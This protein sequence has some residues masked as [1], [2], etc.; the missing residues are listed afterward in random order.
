M[1]VNGFDMRIITQCTAMHYVIILSTAILLY[2]RHSIQ[3]RIAWLA[4]STFVVIA[5]NALRLIIT[6]VIGSISW[7]AFVL[8]HDYLWVAAFS[9][10]TLG[11]WIVWADK[12]FDLTLETV[13]RG[14]MILFACTVAY[15]A[16]LVAMP[17]YGGFIARC[18]S[19]IFK[20]LISEPT[21]SILFN[22]ERM[23]YSYSRDTFSASFAT[24]LMAIALFIG[25]TLSGG[26]YGTGI[27]RRSILGFVI[28]LSL[29]V[30]VIAGGGALLATSGKSA[31]VVLLWTAHGM[32]LE[33]AV[34]WWM[35]RKSNRTV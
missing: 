2:T 31:A 20:L 1:A 32:V 3:Y 9:L 17:L 33:L 19:T 34:L 13:K 29:S 10:L 21:A 14:S 26:N 27:I 35:L 18:S 4:I 28:I 23:V 8:V 16:L 5:A 7:D 25:L 15:A 12:R 22:G 6:G 11:V 30:A 24:D